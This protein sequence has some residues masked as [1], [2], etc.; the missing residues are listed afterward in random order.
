MSN[1]FEFP[2]VSVSK[3]VLMRN[4]SYESEFRQHVYCHIN[5]THRHLIGLARGFVL[6]L[7]HKVTLKWPTVYIYINS[8]QSRTVRARHCDSLVTNA[9][10]KSGVN[11]QILRTGH[12]WTTHL[13]FRQPQRKTT[14]IVDER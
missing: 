2:F 3:R 9:I 10:K 4:H 11:D 12:Q 13:F 6:K 1:R 7:R 14:L 5:K 8:Y